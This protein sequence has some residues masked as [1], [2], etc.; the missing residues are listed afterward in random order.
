MVR[1]SDERI[2]EVNSLFQQPWWLEAIAP[3]QW[4]AAEVRDSGKLIARFPY[5]IQRRYGLTLLH[6]PPLTQT[7]GP[8]ISCST[9]KYEAQLSREHALLEEMIAAL[10]RFDSFRQSFHYSVTNWL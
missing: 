9:G 1:M 3:G 4:G 2:A 6:M 10:P 7:L 8:W 5:V